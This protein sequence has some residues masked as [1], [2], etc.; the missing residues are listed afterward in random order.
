VAR[1][2]AGHRLPWHDHASAQ[3][4]YAAFGFFTVHVPGAS[5]VVPADR[6]VW[7]PPHVPHTL[8]TRTRSELR[9]VYWARSFADLPA[10]AHVVHASGLVRELVHHITERGPIGPGDGAGTR[11]ALV[12]LDQ[13]RALDVAPLELRDPTDPRARDAAILLRD[14]PALGLDVVARKV[15]ASRRTLERQVRAST[16]CRSGGGASA[17]SCCARWNCSPPARR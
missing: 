1:Y 2:P 4:V 10:H 8:E 3:L 9:S 7:V 17:R 5:W 15:G 14:E 12:L 13:L 16:A 6:G 11:L